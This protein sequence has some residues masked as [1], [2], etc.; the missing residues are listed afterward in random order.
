MH[1]TEDPQDEK[2]LFFDGVI[3]EVRLWDTARSADEI[4][5]NLYKTLTG[6]EEDLAVY[7]TFEEGSFSS[8]VK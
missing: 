2:Y 3:D 8:S 4:Q 1:I 7:Y 5:D 6:T